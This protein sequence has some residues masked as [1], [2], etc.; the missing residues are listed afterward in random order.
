MKEIVPRRA[1][2]WVANALYNEKLVAL[3]MGHEDHMA[4]PTR[5]V[6]YCWRHK[7]RWSTSAQSWT[8]SRTFR[9]TRPMR[10]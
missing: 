7:G 5:T 9:T 1:L 8:A 6:S 4:D 10:R 2:A 3:P